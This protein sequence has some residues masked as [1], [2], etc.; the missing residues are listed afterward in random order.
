MA[1]PEDSPASCVT[2][3]RE[4]P[5]REG[6]MRRILAAACVAATLAFSVTLS[7]QLNFPEIPYDAVDPLTVNRPRDLYLGEAAGVPV[8]V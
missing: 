1:R 3:D 5:V 6:V 8:R 4:R 2:T 7:A